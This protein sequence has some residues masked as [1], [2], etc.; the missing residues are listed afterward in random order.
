MHILILTRAIEDAAQFATMAAH[1]GQQFTVTGDLS[2][3][4]SILNRQPPDLLVTE[5]RTIRALTDETLAQVLQRDG[6]PPLLIV[7]HLSPA[8]L[9]KIAQAA[10][11][12]ERPQ[13]VYAVGDL[14]VDTRRKR[15]GVGERWTTLPPLEYRL[16][17]ALIK[18]PD[19]V[20]DYE[21]LMREVW[22][23]EGDRNEA[24]ELLKG[25][26]RQIR[27]RLGLDTAPRRYIHAVRG[28]GYM[29]TAPELQKES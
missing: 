25:H 18:R 23:Y 24:R 12:S 17:L 15:V 5:R 28:F 16:I 8:T 4:R 1:A 29:I 3:L 9:E 10:T 7:D 20:I 11:A 26:I 21:D 19:E 27:R 2:Q 6:G 13:D 22:G 14:C